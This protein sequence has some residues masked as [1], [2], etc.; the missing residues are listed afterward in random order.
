LSPH[1]LRDISDI[2]FYQNYSSRTDIFRAA[3]GTDRY[4]GADKSLALPGRKQDK[5][6][7]L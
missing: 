7:K 4:R 1:I 5:A 2:K 6:T 3:K